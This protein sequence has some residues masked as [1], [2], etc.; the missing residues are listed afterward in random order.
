[1]SDD[2]K[3]VT[4][5]LNKGVNR[6][7]PP[8]ALADGYASDLRHMRFDDDVSFK[9][10]GIAAYFGTTAGAQ[11]NGLFAFADHAG[12]T[13][14]L[15]GLIAKVSKIV[16]GTAT[17]FT[18]A[19]TGALYDRWSFASW[20][21]QVLMTNGIN[22]VQRLVHPYAAGDLADL[23][24]DA[25]C[26]VAHTVRTYMRHAFLLDDTTNPFRVSWSDLD[27]PTDWTAVAGNDA[28]SI[29]LY[30]SKTPVVG[31]DTLKSIFAVY[32]G[33]QI[34]VFQ[35]V[36]GT[37]V[38]SRAIADYS[39]GLWSRGLLV[40]T[41]DA[42]FFMSPTNF[43]A[44]D[45]NR[46]QPIG[47]GIRKEVYAAIGHAIASHSAL[48]NYA[49]AF[50]VRGKGEVWFCVPTN[51]TYPDLAVIFNYWNGAWSLEDICADSS[52]PHT[53]GLACAGIDEGP[54]AYPLL[55][56]NDHMIYSLG[57][58]ENKTLVGGEVAFTGYIDTPEFDDD[59]PESV[60]HIVKVVPDIT[61]AGSHTI[62]FRIGARDTRNS[63]ITWYPLL[64]DA[65]LPFDQDADKHLDARSSGRLIRMRIE[66]SALAS[67]F[68]VNKVTIFYRTIGGR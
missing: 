5:Y 16:S 51:S 52:N 6:D 18:P 26:P 53:T 24:A 57:S 56:L 33:N 25:N 30:E 14:V 7:A 8:G 1:M 47:K 35:Y 62:G 40:A 29:D 50:H 31:G 22:K 10:P 20:G 43:Y 65:A 21:S 34:H 44:F 4:L 9:M 61:A 55:A 15:R 38:F 59:D 39:T 27:D 2:I 36:G 13:H 54:T 68:Q 45:G 12:L 3:K 19:F 17:D 48:I 60:K 11:I 42:H 64:T 37:Y 32:T 66:T 67:P 28:G 49:F 23:T 58:G 41:E 63:A 46:P